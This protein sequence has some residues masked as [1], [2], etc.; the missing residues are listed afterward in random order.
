MTAVVAIMNKTG[1][2]L[3]ADSAVTISKGNAEHK[4]YN[5]ANKLFALSKY[6]P[7][8]IMIYNQ[9]EVLNVP[10]E[11][12][13]K[14]YKKQL[15]ENSFATINEY[16]KNFLNFL[17]TNTLLNLTN[18][19][20]E[21]S[22]IVNIGLKFLNQNI[23]NLNAD[24]YTEETI[25]QELIKKID[26]ES[27]KVK[28]FPQIESLVPSD[29]SIL[30]LP[31][32]IIEEIRANFSRPLKKFYPTIKDE[33]IEILVEKYKNLLIELLTR[34]N[35]NVNFYSGIVFVGYGEAQIY[36]AL[37]SI[38]IEGSFAKKIRYKIIHDV[39]INNSKDSGIYPYAQVDVMEN[40]L[41]GIDTKLHDTIINSMTKSIE[42]S[43]EIYN[44]LIT[45]QN[46][47][48]L[49]STNLQDLK[50]STIK[51]V[52]EEVKKNIDDMI[53]SHHTIPTLDAIGSL[54]KEYLAELAESLI[55]LTFLKRRTSLSLESVGGDIDVAIISKGDGFIWKKRKH[56]FD[57]E[58]NVGFFQ[59]YYRQ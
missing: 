23:L 22:Y 42:K 58:L 14:L 53:M 45:T 48:T 4:V 15:S 40:F 59:N 43:L 57:K 39:Q 27:E 21:N 7:V 12:I 41:L 6:H 29:S 10:W 13:I 44:S 24:D 17:S 1:V 2:A 50:N 8:G 35:F 11:I 16:A 19:S 18:E 31:Q 49:D 26:L 54:S 46:D 5:T 20:Q 32:E 51:Y 34:D 28:K 36:P 33:N 52:V 56:Y 38:L 9:A 47:I 37:Y 55:Y 30:D 3:A 25:L